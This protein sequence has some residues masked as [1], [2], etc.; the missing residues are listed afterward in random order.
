[1]RAVRGG[2]PP[3]VLLLADQLNRYGYHPATYAGVG[4]HRL[5]HLLLGVSGAGRHHGAAGGGVRRSRYDETIIKGNEAIVKG[6]IL[7][8][9]RAFYGYPITPASEIA[10]AAAVYMPQVGGVF[11]QAESEVAAINMLYGAAADGRARHDGV[12]RPGHQ[13]DAGGHQLYRRRRAALRHRGHHARRA[14]PGQHRAGA[15]RLSPGGEGR[16][17]RQLSHPGAGAQFRAGDGGPDQR[18]PS[19]WPTVIAIPCSCW[20]MVTS[21][22]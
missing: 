15:G 3:K 6:A 19:T 7:A 8:G 4:L 22:R 17:P 12:E 10:E 5:R 1:M 2:C 20:R 16:R 14:G 21:G 9:C 11:L 13:P 18:W